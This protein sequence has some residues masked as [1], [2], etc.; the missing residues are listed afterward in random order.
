MAEFKIFFKESVWKD[1]KQTPKKD[2]KQILN[3]IEGLAHEP[4]PS[5]CQKLSGSE[6]YRIRQ[7]KYRIIYSVQDDELTVW[8]VKVGHRKD[9]YR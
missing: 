6:K 4:R 9:V 2:L 1:F 8:V 7:G 5:G 3:K